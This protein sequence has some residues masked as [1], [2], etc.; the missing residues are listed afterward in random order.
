M[1]IEVLESQ[2]PGDHGRDHGQDV[3]PLPG[4]GLAGKPRVEAVQQHHSGARL[5]D[6]VVDQPVRHPRD[7]GRNRAQGVVLSYLEPL[8][9]HPGGQEPCV[10]RHRGALGHAGGTA[11]GGELADVLDAVTGGGQAPAAFLGNGGREDFLQ[12]KA[13][14]RRLVPGRQHMAQLR[15]PDLL[16]Q[17]Q[18]PEPAIGGRHDDGLGT[19]EGDEGLELRAPQARSH[20]H[21]PNPRLLTRQPRQEELRGVGHLDEHATVALQPQVQQRHGEGVRKLGDLRPGEAT[22]AVHQRLL[23]PGPARVVVAEVRRRLERHVARHRVQQGCALIRHGLRSGR[24]AHGRRR[25]RTVF[26]LHPRVA[27]QTGAEPTTGHPGPRVKP[28]MTGGGPEW[29]RITVVEPMTRRWAEMTV[30]GFMQMDPNVRFR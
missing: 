13:A 17:L 1:V 2:Q 11:G 25:P 15:N 28:G 10:E 27:H 3:G 9:V 5:A 19:G 24:A 26:L 22:P 6:A 18:M 12:G 30:T 14:R 21:E 7:D 20:G 4:H 16:Q 23:P 29:S 8:Q